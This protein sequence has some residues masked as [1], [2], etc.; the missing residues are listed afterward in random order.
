MPESDKQ[1]MESKGFYLDTEA[2]RLFGGNFERWSGSGV[3]AEV[4]IKRDKDTGVAY[5]EKWIKNDNW[6]HT[7]RPHRMDGPSLVKR[8]RITGA[9][10]SEKFHVN[11]K[12]I[13]ERRYPENEFVTKRPLPGQIQGQ[14]YLPFSSK[15]PGM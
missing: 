4:W 5:W 15:K 2:M 10:I 8:N 6:P 3:A 1:D 12:K 14:M 11:G 9:V 13:A 7:S